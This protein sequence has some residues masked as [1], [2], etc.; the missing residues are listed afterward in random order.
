MR[1][2]PVQVTWIGYPNSTGLSAVDYRITDAIC[3]PEDTQQ[4]W[5]CALCWL[6]HKST[7]GVA[8]TLQKLARFLSLLQLHETFVLL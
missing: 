1:V 3:D 6:T 5:P 2:A 7:Q 4:V 8:S